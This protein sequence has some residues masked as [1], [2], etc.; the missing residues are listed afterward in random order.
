MA[1]DL[2]AKVRAESAMAAAREL[3]VG[4]A[5]LTESLPGLAVNVIDARETADELFV[6][7]EIEKL[8]RSRPL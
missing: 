5:S 6:L 1:L 2:A 3:E 7:F 8:L 4:L